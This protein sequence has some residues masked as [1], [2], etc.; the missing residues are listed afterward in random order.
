MAASIRE[1]C[2][3]AIKA[4]VLA[5]PGFVGVTRSRTDKFQANESPSANIAPGHADPNEVAI[6]KVDERL[7]LTVSIFARATAG[8]A[9]DTV[10]DPFVLATHAALMAE[11]TLGGLAVDMDEAGTTWNFDESDRASL[12]VDMRFTLWTRHDRASLTT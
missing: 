4:R 3:A 9:A 8:V 7:D 5:V 1:Q 2:L 11:P 12:M 10:A 6:G